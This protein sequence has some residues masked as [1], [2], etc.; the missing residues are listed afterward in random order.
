MNRKQRKLPLKYVREEIPALKPGQRMWVEVGADGRDRVWCM[1]SEGV[2]LKK[3]N[4]QKRGIKPG[5][6]FHAD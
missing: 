1:P 4:L 3:T 2:Q 6:I 5:D